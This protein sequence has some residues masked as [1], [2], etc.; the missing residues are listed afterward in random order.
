[1]AVVPREEEDRR[2]ARG[3]VELNGRERATAETVGTERPAACC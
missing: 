2:D 1:M 3:T